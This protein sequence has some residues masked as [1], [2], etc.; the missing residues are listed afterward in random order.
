M[1]LFWQFVWVV[2]KTTHD[3]N[4]FVTGERL[5]FESGV[6]STYKHKFDLAGHGD[7]CSRLGL[8]DAT[9][10]VRT[11]HGFCFECHHRRGCCAADDLYRA[12]VECFDRAATGEPSSHRSGVALHDLPAREVC[13][14]HSRLFGG[15][16]TSVCDRSHFNR[17]P[18]YCAFSRH[19]FWTPVHR[20]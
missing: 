1:K 8:S 16:Q 12:L 19:R 20:R 4:A 11:D 5:C 15:A 18:L 7:N 10:H 9:I 13:H 3:Y 2:R 6:C 14:R 17:S